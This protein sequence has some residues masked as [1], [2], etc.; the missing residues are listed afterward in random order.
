MMKQAW[1][2]RAA[3]LGIAASF[4]SPLPH[5]RRLRACVV[6]HG[7]VALRDESARWRGR[8]LISVTPAQLDPATAAELAADLPGLVP[9]EGAWELEL[10]LG[11]D[12]VVLSDA[13][14]LAAPWPA[15]TGVELVATLSATA[16]YRGV[17]TD[18]ALPVDATCALVRGQACAWAAGTALA[19]LVARAPD[20]HLALR[21]LDQQV[22]TVRL[23]GPLHDGERV[24]Q[25][26]VRMRSGLTSARDCDDLPTALNAVEV[27]HPGLL[28]TVQD[29][30]GRLG[31]WAVGVPPSGPFDDRAF[32]YANRLVG[33]PEGLA[34]LEMT[35]VGPTLR[36]HAPAIV[37][38]TGAPRTATLDGAPLPMWQPVAVAAGSELRCGPPGPAGCRGYL[39]VRH[40]FAVAGYLGS[41]ATFDLGGF[42][43]FA[44]RALAAGDLI[45]LER[46]STACLL[47]TSPGPRDH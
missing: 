34:G 29:W 17:L 27:V 20:H 42:G 35:L 33:N 15:T 28:T 2:E 43:G 40:G 26:I 16:P 31:H 4:G 32:R 5:G 22:S 47:Y 6:D 7:I 9:D 44:G 41:Q 10:V 46:P 13:R 30:P 19:T 3:S 39:A 21:A 38:L 24:R 36:F 1:K 23:G 12:G 8:L 14:P 18:L 11:D 45:P 25:A 37:A